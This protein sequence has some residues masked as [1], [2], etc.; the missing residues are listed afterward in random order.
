M[1]HSQNS[2]EDIIVSA[3]ARIQ[4]KD[5]YV[6][7]LG[8]NDGEMLSNSRA[9]IELGWSGCMIEPDYEAFGRLAAL[10]GQHKSVRLVQAAVD[11][12]RGMAVLHKSGSFGL[13]SSL[14]DSPHRAEFIHDY[15]VPKITPSQ[16][17]DILPRG[18][19]VITCDIEGRS[20]EVV[21]AFPL[22]SWL[23]QCIC[24]EHDNR[25]VEIAAWGNEKGYR[26]VELNAENI[27]LVRR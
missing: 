18:P 12:E 27:I 23:V 3:C 8:A 14:Y 22:S 16:I 19:D 10:Y 17:V 21:Q 4:P 26:V 6:L 24:I 20:F 9:L 13:V 11:T 15:W 7:D 2:E 1:R 25:A 5:G